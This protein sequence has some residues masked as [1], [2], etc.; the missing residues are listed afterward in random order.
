MKVL[1]LSLCT[2]IVVNNPY[3]SAE[4]AVRAERSNLKSIIKREEFEREA[5]KVMGELGS[6]EKEK[7]SQSKKQ[8]EEE[9]E[10]DKEKDGEGDE[11]EEEEGEEQSNANHNEVLQVGK[12]KAETMRNLVEKI[13]RDLPTLTS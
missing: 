5:E 3:R 7:E 9:K 4:K 13:I 12:L 8:K 10:E 2:N 6:K 11:D 1:V